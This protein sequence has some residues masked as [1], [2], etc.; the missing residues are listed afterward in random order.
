[1]FAPPPS[2]PRPAAPSTPCLDC[3]R[4]QCESACDPIMAAMGVRTRQA[5]GIGSLSISELEGLVSHL[6]QFID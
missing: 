5:T 4:G 3:A 1:M 6:D 2:R